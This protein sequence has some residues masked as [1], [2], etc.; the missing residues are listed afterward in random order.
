[1]KEAKQLF[2]QYVFNVL[3]VEMLYADVWEGNIN[4]MKSLE[5]SGYKLVD[6]TNEIFVKT[7]KMM[8]KYIF[9]LSKNDYQRHCASSSTQ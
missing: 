9:A 5:S 4:S 3:T 7:G 1:M 2:Y 8:Q 6:T